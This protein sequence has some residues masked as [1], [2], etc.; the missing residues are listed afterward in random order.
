MKK[1][2]LLPLLLIFLGQVLAQTS[3][4]PS[5]L[6][7]IY[8]ASGS[9][10]GQIEGK[11]KMVIASEV[12]SNS[13]Q[14]L[15]DNQ[16]LGL[17]VYGHN[18]EGDCEDVEFMVDLNNGNKTAVIDAIKTVKPLGK[19]PLAYSASLVIEELRQSKT[20]AT[21]ILITDGIES[22]D[23]DICEVVSTAKEEGIDFKLHIVGFGLK[24]EETAQLKCAAEAGNGTYTNAEDEVDLGGVL[25]EVT[26]QTIDDPS[27]NFSVFA[28]K[29]G[30]PVDAWVKA[31]DVVSK[32]KPIAVRTYQDTAL[33]Y[34]PPSRYNFEVVPLE[35]SDVDMITVT[36]L[37]SFE[38]KL[39]HQ[40]I[41]FDAG[42]LA[43]SVTNNGDNWD[44]V[45]KVMDQN[46]KVVASKRT[47][48]SP[49]EIEVNPGRY[50]I[51]VQALKIEGLGTM[52]EI[53]SID[54]GSGQG[55]P[56]DVAFETGTFQIRTTVGGEM[57][58]TI[59]TL[60]ESVSG[61]NVAGART[62][63][64][65]ADFLLTPGTYNVK[66]VPLGEHKDKAAQ[67]FSIEVKAEELVKKEI[68]F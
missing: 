41:S 4:N 36:D 45:V 30:K 16:D 57:I 46:G 27:G 18:R 33:F 64:R 58:D 10:W 50:S 19:T 9:M 15:P 43:I 42:K 28:V 1:V 25:A 3:E 68:Q 39:S 54:I 5:P 32:R 22:C 11:S 53:E 55:T 24:D 40:T 14:N 59:V 65:G 49:K 37:E 44:A 26:T 67:T 29:N 20:K 35:G 21:I 2:L 52:Q 48:D 60:N 66:V 62:N 34:L 6:Y 8:D 47:Y 23:G 7:F 31:Y 61:K 63:T 12:L 17:V 51:S 38:D 13:V 56:I